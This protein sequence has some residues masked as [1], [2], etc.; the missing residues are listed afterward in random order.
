MWWWL[1]GNTAS[2]E[3]ST[4]CLAAMQVY[5]DPLT[6]LSCVILM[7]LMKRAD[8]MQY[9]RPILS[10]ILRR[11]DEPRK[12]IQVIAGPRQVG[13]TTIAVELQKRLNSLAIYHTA[14]DTPVNNPVWIDQIWDSLRVRMKVEK[15]GSAVLILDEMQKINDWSAVVKKHWDRDT[16]ENCDIK[17]VLLGSSR[18]LIMDGLSESLMGRYEL[19]YAGHWSLAEMEHA[20][21]FTPEQY[22][23]F[24]GYP[25]AATLVGDEMRFKEY[26][27]DAIIEPTM[28]RD[29]LMTSKVDKPAL[30]R[31][32]LE[33]GIGYSTQ[34]MSYNRILGQLQDAGNTTTLARYLK[35]LDQSGLLGGL[36]KHSGRLIETKGSIPKFQVHNNALLSALSIDTFQ[37]ALIDRRAWG[38]VFESS[39]GS[40]L[41][42]Q[43]NKVPNAKL[44][45]WRENGSEVDYVLTYGSEAI[46]I[47]VKSGDEGLSEKASRKFK[48]NF[49]SAKLI[50]VGKHGIPYESF[51]RTGI[52]ELFAE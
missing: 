8:D 12:F 22:Q 42:D 14:D 1:E 29:I 35:L 33:V 15:I 17:L 3:P 24:G 51:M 39:V 38:N 50:L 31:Q 4:S 23:W 36:N 20:F 47:E 9:Q 26:I 40:H 13:K 45:Y 5:F 48:E 37:K 34:I 25:G 43:V 52:R 16:R 44:H 27:R 21:G 30:L 49:P 7:N 28:I 2:L 10:E 6:L 18:L 32:L 46:G 19:N 41:I 11:L